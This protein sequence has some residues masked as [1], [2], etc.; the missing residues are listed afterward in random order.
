M[1]QRGVGTLAAAR[2][3]FFARKLNIGPFVSPLGALL[4]R[5][6]N[7]SVYRGVRF[8]RRDGA[9]GR[10]AGRGAAGNR[11]QDTGTLDDPSVRSLESA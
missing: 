9:R 2:I 1:R 4:W 8:V 3:T 7:P 11:T 6:A 10:G 5:S